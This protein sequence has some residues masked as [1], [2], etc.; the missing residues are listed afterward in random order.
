M[1]HLVT[2]TTQVIKRLQFFT[3]KFHLANCTLGEWADWGECEP[4]NGVCGNG[5][6]LRFKT[7]LLPSRNGGNCDDN[8]PES[9]KCTKDC[10]P[11]ANTG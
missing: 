7:E 3:I 6:R 11:S 5:T 10:P 8:I 4:S 9:E 2:S 1:V